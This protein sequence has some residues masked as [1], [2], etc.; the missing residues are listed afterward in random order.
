MDISQAT[1]PHDRIFP[2]KERGRS[3]KKSNIKSGI[4][5]RTILEDD[6]QDENT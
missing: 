6:L 2:R 1:D 3:G 4:M 5:H